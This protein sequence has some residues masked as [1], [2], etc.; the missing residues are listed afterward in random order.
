MYNQIF[1]PKVEIWHLCSV[2][3]LQTA[4]QTP[5]AGGWVPCSGESS[6]ILSEYQCGWFCWY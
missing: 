3:A 4:Q 2:F 5:L 6:R 1:A